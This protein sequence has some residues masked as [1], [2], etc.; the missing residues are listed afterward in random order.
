M[1]SSIGGKIPLA[2]L[3]TSELIIQVHSHRGPEHHCVRHAR[4]GGET[5]CKTNKNWLYLFSGGLGSLYADPH[6]PQQRGLGHQRGVQVRGLR[7]AAEV[8]HSLEDNTSPDC[9]WEMLEILGGV[10]EDNFRLFMREI[11]LYQKL[12][13]DVNIRG[14]KKPSGGWEYLINP[15]LPNSDRHSGDKIPF[16]FFVNFLLRLFNISEPSSA[17]S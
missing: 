9:R 17:V 2:L 7:G 1:S 6:H 15:P 3:M 5:N 8:L 4:P 13:E 16:P 14:S 10:R 11:R 12:Q